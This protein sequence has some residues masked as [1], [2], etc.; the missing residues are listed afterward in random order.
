[1]FPHRSAL[2]NSGRPPPRCRSSGTWGLVRRLAAP[3]LCALKTLRCR[4]DL[5]M[6]RAAA[7]TWCDLP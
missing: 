4:A 5:A 1:M 2:E 6:S 7:A 3:P